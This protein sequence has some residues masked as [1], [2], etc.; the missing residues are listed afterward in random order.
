MF[1]L[2]LIT[3][4][5]GNSRGMDQWPIEGVDT[6]AQMRAILHNP[7]GYLKV[8]IDYFSERTIDYTQDIFM[9]LGYLKHMNAFVVLVD[10]GI[11]IFLSIFDIREKDQEIESFYFSIPE[12]LITYFS[13]F[14][15]IILSATALYITFNPVGSLSVNGFQPRYFWPIVLPLLMTLSSKKIRNTFNEQSI[16]Y[17]TFFSLLAINL[18]FMWT[19]VISSFII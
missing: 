12:K 3:Y 7:L 11:L 1:L 15:M 9:S 13:I 2:A 16:Y 5:Y 17:L 19:S 8:V 4:S 6:T 14:C 10:I 18:S